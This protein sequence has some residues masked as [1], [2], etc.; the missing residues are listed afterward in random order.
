LSRTFGDRRREG[1]ILASSKLLT[2]SA[3]LLSASSSWGRVRAPWSRRPLRLISAL[4]TRP[5]LLPTRPGFRRRSSPGS[6]GRSAVGATARPGG[7]LKGDRAPLLGLPLL[8][9]R[10]VFPLRTGRGT[11]PRGA[12]RGCAASARAPTPAAPAFEGRRPFPRGRSPR[13]SAHLRTNPRTRV[14][15]P[16]SARRRPSAP[17]ASLPP[18]RHAATVPLGLPR[19]GGSPHR[20]P[21]PS[22]RLRLLV[23]A[24]DPLRPAASDRASGPAGRDTSAIPIALPCAT[25]S[26][27]R[28]PRDPRGVRNRR[29][30]SAERENFGWPSPPPFDR[31]R[32]LPSLR[33]ATRLGSCDSIDRSRHR[34]VRWS[35][36]YQCT[37]NPDPGRSI[38]RHGGPSRLPYQCTDN[39]RPPARPLPSIAFTAPETA[40]ALSRRACSF[41]SLPR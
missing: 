15:V 39:P 31:R 30:S 32:P 22:L 24:A 8:P 17:A 6:I 5:R 35:G 41:S 18:P 1:T 33:G 11:R 20:A 21:S 25:R 34:P 37:D 27:L 14:P 4:I 40:A 23:L 3:G 13:P 9:A 16:F 36:P 26:D 7:A 2:A 10:S 19:G 38:V 12:D 29:T 28:R